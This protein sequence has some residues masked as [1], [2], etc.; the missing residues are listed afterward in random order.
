M[1]RRKAINPI[2]G[3]RKLQLADEL[4]VRRQLAIRCGGVY[5]QTTAMGGYCVGGTCEICGLPPDFRQ[6]HPHE[7]VHRSQG[8]RLSLDNSLMVCG[9]CHDIEHGIR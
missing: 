8:G 5:V 1:L 9:R 3:K 4:E 7:K 6:L 2:S